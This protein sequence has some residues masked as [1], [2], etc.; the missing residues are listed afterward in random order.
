MKTRLSL[1]PPLSI[2]LAIVI[3]IT[4]AMSES[5]LNYQGKVTAGGTNFSGSGYF[6]FRLVDGNGNGLWGNDGSSGTN[7]P[8]ASLQVEVNNGLFNVELGLPGPGMSP[9]PPTV[10]HAENITLRT[11]FS[12]NN[13]TFELLSPDVSV[14]PTDLAAFDSGG[15]VVVDD[16][17]G[18]DFT[19]IQ[20][21]IDFVA[22]NSYFETVLLMPGYYAISSPLLFPAGRSVRLCGI[23]NREDVTIE[24]TNMGVA[25]NCGNTVLQNITLIGSPSLDDGLS[26]AGYSLSAINCAFRGNTNSSVVALA[27]LGGQVEMFN[28]KVVS[29]YAGSTGVYMTADS[30]LKMKHCI[31]AAQSGDNIGIYMNA[32]GDLDMESCVIAAGS[33]TSLMTLNSPAG[34]LRFN[35]CDFQ[36]MISINGPS[37]WNLLFRNCYLQGD[38]NDPAALILSPG[39]AVIDH[40]NISMT[41]HPA[42]WVDVGSGESA[43]VAVRHSHIETLMGAS[44]F[45]EPAVYLANHAANN[46][47]DASM[48][49]SWSRIMNQFGAG[50]DASNGE[51]IVSHTL[52]DAGGDA[53]SIAAGEAE[54]S[55]S[56]IEGET[57]GITAAAQAEISVINSEVEGENNGITIDD[58]SAEIIDSSVFGETN[59][60]IYASGTSELSLTRSSLVGSDDDTGSGRALYALLDGADEPVVVFHSVLDACGA[61][62]TLEVDGG[63]YF[64]VNTTIHSENDRCALLKNE[65]ST[66]M[67]NNCELVN[68]S[69]DN[70][71]LV[72]ELY[73]PSYTTN[74]P[75]VSIYNSCLQSFAT[76]TVYSIGP[77]LYGSTN[78]IAAG[79]TIFSHN[80]IDTYFATMT[81]MGNGCFLMPTH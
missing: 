49:I 27:T 42:L 60:G 25:V 4:S 47:S 77:T 37:A 51:I 39:D 57:N 41:D 46:P 69:E 66:V 53:I 73:R 11:W 64:M 31:V 76:S 24:N 59:C 48:E 23:G 22:T 3:P 72:I 65:N 78:L 20:E 29:D 50:I 34:T 15:T 70:T 44:P 13:T 6:K 55:W 79:S 62:P 74:P 68:S 63:T 35:S 10:F 26:P 56:N 2:V 33:G 9:I 43:R 7:E 75:T 58:C 38:T 30:T 45:G 67:F 32:G 17:P 18:G 71:N 5:M 19:N 1:I 52:L 21:A 14:R 80:P 28:C 61:G 54:C 8:A 36:N 12:T 40:C 81:N 16:D